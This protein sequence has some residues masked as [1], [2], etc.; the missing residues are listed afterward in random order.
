MGKRQE[1]QDQQTQRSRSQGVMM[2]GGV[3]D[4]LDSHVTNMLG[5]V[6]AALD[7]EMNR[8]ETLTEDD[9]GV[10]RKNRMNEMKRKAEE[11]QEWAFNGHGSLTKIEQKDFFDT[12]K[13]SHRVVVLF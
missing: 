10:I 4:I 11:R 8:M 9:L 6:E 2:G 12:T 3:Q 7:D 13:K 5:Q 1:S